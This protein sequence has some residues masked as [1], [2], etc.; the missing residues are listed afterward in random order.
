VQKT[1]THTKNKAPLLGTITIIW[2]MEGV[3]TDYYLGI[4]NYSSLERIQNI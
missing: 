3:K 2:K 4:R 1:G